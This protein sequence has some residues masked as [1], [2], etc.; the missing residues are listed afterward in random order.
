MPLVQLPI[1]LKA[2]GWKKNEAIATRAKIIADNYDEITS[3]DLK[4]VNT[5]AELKAKA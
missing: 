4:T 1:T 3:K 5:L 2:N